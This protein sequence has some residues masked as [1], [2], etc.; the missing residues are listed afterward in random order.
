MDTFDIKPSAF[1]L[2]DSNKEALD[3]FALATS[4]YTHLEFFLQ[5]I[6]WKCSQ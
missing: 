2:F 3:M 5:R 1:K 4:C 6:C